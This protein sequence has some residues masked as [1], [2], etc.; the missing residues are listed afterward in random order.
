MN[1]NP[2]L[3]VYQKFWYSKILLS[4]PNANQDDLI[5]IIRVFGDVSLINSHKLR[6]FFKY[7]P[8]DKKQICLHTRKNPNYPF[9]DFNNAHDYIQF[10]K[11]CA[12]FQ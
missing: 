3:T 1:A 10:F 11:R 2:R 4:I 9:N 12:V 8:D 5:A 6:N 7:I